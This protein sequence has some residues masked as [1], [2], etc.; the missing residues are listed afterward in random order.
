MSLMFK[1]SEYVLDLTLIQIIVR[2]VIE[3][4]RPF[5][6]PSSFQLRQQRKKKD[7]RIYTWLN[8]V[9]ANFELI[10]QDLIEES[11]SF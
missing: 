7:S 8:P 11:P 10:V 6:C 2:L 1:W 9:H 4:T 5:I 3:K